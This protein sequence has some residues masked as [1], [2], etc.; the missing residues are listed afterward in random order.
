ME[1]TLVAPQQD[2]YRLMP[3]RNENRCSH[4]VCTGVFSS[5]VVHSS[6]KVELLKC[7]P[8]AEWIRKMWCVNAFNGMLFSF[9]GE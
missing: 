1:N 2:K 5:S 7:L 8:V 4:K 3:K 9:V 6:Q